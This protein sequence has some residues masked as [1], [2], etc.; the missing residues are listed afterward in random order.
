MQLKMH[1]LKYDA[2]NM[3]LNISV[4]PNVKLT[5]SPDKVLPLTLP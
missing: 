4:A 1:N 2:N 5:S 3:L